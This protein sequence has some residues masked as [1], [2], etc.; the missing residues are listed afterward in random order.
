MKRISIPD[1]TRPPLS[2]ISV[3]DEQLSLVHETLT[4]S[5]GLPLHVLAGDGPEVVRLDLAVPGGIRY[6]RQAL[7]AVFTAR[8]IK[9]GTRTTPGPRIDEALD[10]YGSYLEASAERDQAVVSLFAPRRFFHEVLPLFAEV[11]QDA[12]FPRDMLEVEKRHQHQEYLVNDRRVA[13]VA[14]QH[15]GSL[16]FGQD[17]PYGHYPSAGDFALLEPEVLLEHLERCYASTQA[18][19]ILSGNVDPGVVDQVGKAFGHRALLSPGTSHAV[20]DQGQGAGPGDFRVFRPGTLQTALRIGRTIMP[21]SHPDF[22]G[23]QFLVSL[24]GGY[25]G[26]RLMKNIREDKGYTYG[27]GAFIQAYQEAA[28]LVVSTE[29]GTEVEDLALDEVR[30]EMQRL[31]TEPVGAQEMELV[32]NYILGSLQRSMDGPMSRAERLRGFLEAG[33]PPDQFVRFK[34]FLQTISAEDVLRLAHQYLDPDCMTILRVGETENIGV[35]NI[36]FE[37][38]GV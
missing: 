9:E 15:F 37:A 20:S 30:K 11:W 36:P 19:L 32:R 7:A 5:N 14:R 18:F 1:R 12:V 27:I 3:A 35:G 8:L 24:L 23:M 13:W 38:E 25:F 16:L 21:R 2:G 26:S 29:V 17:H 33:E 22:M 31:R 34:R 6:Q 4:L 28:S 10:Y